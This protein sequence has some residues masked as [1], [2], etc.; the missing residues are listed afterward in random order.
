MYCNSLF[1]NVEDRLLSKRKTPPCTYPPQKT[2]PQLSCSGITPYRDNP[3]REFVDIKTSTM[4]A[5]RDTTRRIGGND[6]NDPDFAR[7]CRQPVWPRLG[8]FA[9]FTA[10]STLSGTRFDH[11]D[12]SVAPPTYILPG[13]CYSIFSLLE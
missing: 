2:P 4:H 11:L 10:L 7:S 13:S 5:R 9:G 1:Q 12:S 8:W 6:S 3:R